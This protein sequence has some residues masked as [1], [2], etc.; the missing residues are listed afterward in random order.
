[1]K[2]SYNLENHSDGD[3]RQVYNKVENSF[4]VRENGAPFS[5]MADLDVSDVII[6]T[7]AENEDTRDRHNDSLI[8]DL[9]DV[10][11]LCHEEEK[12]RSE[13]FNDSSSKNNHINVLDGV[14]TLSENGLHKAANED[15]TL[16]NGCEIE[17][18]AS[19]NIHEVSKMGLNSEEMERKKLTNP[20]EEKESVQD[21]D[22]EAVKD[23]VLKI[24]NRAR[25]IV[26]KES[27]NSTK[28]KNHRSTKPWAQRLLEIFCFRRK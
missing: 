11:V 7:E 22:M 15:E 5:S 26:Q 6:K 24:V 25:E 21:V 27:E 14:N 3:D 19:T 1:M 12:P 10:S 16:N 20:S 28:P 18:N 9:D 2:T 8:T 13:C 17:L 23:Y 4:S